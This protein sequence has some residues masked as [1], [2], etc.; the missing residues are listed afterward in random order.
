MLINNGFSA[1]VA[2]VLTK[3]TTYKYKLPQG[4]P[5][6]TALAN[7]AFS[8]VDKRLSDLCEENNLVYTRFVDDI[9]ISGK[10][11]FKELSNVIVKFIVE[12][13][14]KISRKKTGYKIGTVDITGV[15]LHNNYFD[16]NIKLFNSHSLP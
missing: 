14:Y 8:A 13:G 12:A 5:T 7:L 11:D 1:D 16:T 4:T 6:S 3:L 2:S 10:T 15:K 9:A